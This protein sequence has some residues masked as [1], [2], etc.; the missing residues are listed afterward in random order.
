MVVKHG[1]SMLCLAKC[2]ITNITALPKH[3]SRTD[4]GEEIVVPSDGLTK[5]EKGSLVSCPEQGALV[6]ADK[7]KK[8]HLP[9][10]GCQEHPLA[11]ADPARERLSSQ[12]QPFSSPFQDK[13]LLSFFSASFHLSH[14]PALVFSLSCICQ[15]LQCFSMDMCSIKKRG[16]SFC[17]CKRKKGGKN[18][19]ERLPLDTH[20]RPHTVTVQ[21]FCFLQDS[22]SGSPPF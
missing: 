22:A 6:G 4:L 12:S 18:T 19:V 16:G 11:W 17:G 9:S 5:V 13:K 14:R 15:S 2:L 21:H 7:L 20:L 10:L 1:V 8:L 3:G